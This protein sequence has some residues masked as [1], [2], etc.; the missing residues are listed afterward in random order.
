MKTAVYNAPPTVASFMRDHSD[1][2]GLMGPF[3]SGKSVGCLMELIRRAREQKPDS[4]NVRKTRWAIIRNTYP[5]LRDT[6]RKTFEDWVE[7]EFRLSTDWSEQ[8]FSCT[9]KMK[10]PDGTRVEAEFLFRALDRPEHVKKLLSLEL[11]GAWINEAR[12]VPYT[13]VKMLS[14]RVGRFPSMRDGGPTWYGIIMDTNPPDDDSWWYQLFEEEK[15]KNAKIFKQPGG[16]DPKAENLGHWEDK[17]G[18]C[19]G[20]YPQEKPK[21][22]VWVKHLPDDYYERLAILNAGDPLWLKVHVGAEYGPTMDGRPVYPEYKDT[23]HSVDEKLIPR[24]DGAVILLG[25][26]F[27]LTPA[28]ALAQRDLKDGQIQVF[29]EVV[30]DDLGAVRFFEDVARHLK[31]AYNGR[32]VHGTGDP[33]GD[34]RSQVD[35]RTPYDIA[36]G[37]GIPLSPAHTNDFERR[38]DAVGRALTRL[39]LLGRPALVISSKCKM[40]RK[41]MNGKYCLR[42]VASAGKEKFRDVPDKNEYSHVAEALQYLM[43]GQGED[44]KAISGAAQHRSQHFIEVEMCG[45]RRRR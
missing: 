44:V 2:R 7:K 39:T 30:A 12:E 34:I 41:A 15:P 19:T 42:R 28:V 32:P 27:G 6:T 40:L 22:S 33:G 4:E 9:V 20:H 10:L 23:V 8:E 31:S 36:R 13:V 29:D 37:Q 38:R 21:D 17:Y 16:R 45:V 3:G 35:E 24:M 5:E 18:N 11:T 1:L 25:A 43:L 26:D 14:G